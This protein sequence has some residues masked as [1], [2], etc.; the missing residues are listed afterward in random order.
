M[1]ICNS[2][3]I[4]NKQRAKRCSKC[5]SKRFA[6]KWVKAKRP[7]NRQFAVEI[8]ET[9]PDYGEV[10]R[11]ITLTKWWLGDSTTFHIPTLEQ[12]EEV[13]RIINEELGSII[14]WKTKK[15]LVKEIKKKKGKAEIKEI[16][17][18]V[19]Q[20]PEFILKV[21]E[22]INFRRIEEKDHRHVI[23]ILEKLTSVMTNSDEGFKIAFKEVV[24]KLPDQPKRA[25]DELSELLK[26]W[27]LQQ[28]TSVTLEV[29]RRLSTIEL[30][31]ERILDDKT[32]EI[33]G[34]NS[35]HR[36]LE[37]AMW[38][39]DER[40][41]LL[42]SNETLRKII[43]KEMAKKDKKKFAKKKPDFVCGTVGDKLI[44][45]EIK[46]P[47]HK[48]A[49]DDLNQLETYLAVAEDHFSHKFFEAYLIGR[50]IG[51]DLKKIM[52]FRKSN[53]KIWTY[54]DLVDSTEKRYCDYLKSI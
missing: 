13:Q 39:V 19:E 4:E 45:L 42:H 10:Q 33:K 54:S 31:K 11:R 21:L 12:W 32:H 52:K 53:F 43:G 29:K 20:Y 15:K 41:W 26:S 25:L 34:K 38:I 8:T 51:P 44:I 35:I 3:G 1:K 27:S 9:N 6:P 24:S 28:I 17:E 50:K 5:G 40:Y 46:R 2:C 47:S 49:V 16:T 7:I 14:G 22:S 48:L 37:K 18:L 36:I 30:F 23:E